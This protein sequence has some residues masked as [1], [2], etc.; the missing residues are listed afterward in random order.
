MK[1]FIRVL[2]ALYGAF[3]ASLYG[4]VSACPSGTL[5]QP[6]KEWLCGHRLLPTWL[7]LI[8][9]LFIAFMFLL[10]KHSLAYRRTMSVLLLSTYGI[11]AAFETVNS[12]AW[13]QVP[14][15]VSVLLAAIG[16][17]LRKKWGSVL[18]CALSLVFAVIYAWSVVT[19]IQ[20]GYI[21][22]VRPLEAVLSFMPGIAFGLL[23]GFCCYV[24]IQQHNPEVGRV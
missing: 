22:T 1:S 20:S 8:P 3:F 10:G 18:V 7:L 16:I 11:F 21:K 14:F 23:A 9:V 6:W 15:S 13:W 17:A 2:I 4:Q 5:E 12:H 24:A 19:G